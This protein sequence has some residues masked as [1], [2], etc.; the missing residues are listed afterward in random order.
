M[1]YRGQSADSL[2]PFCA[3]GMA[4]LPRGC[5]PYIVV[6]GLTRFAAKHASRFGARELTS[7]V[8]AIAAMS[9]ARQNGGTEAAEA[10]GAALATLA[11]R[12]VKIDRQFAPAGIAT[13][14][15][16]FAA[17]RNSGSNLVPAESIKTLYASLIAGVQPQV[18]EPGR[19]AAAG[20]RWRYAFSC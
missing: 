10:A 7:S 8:W 11:E 14:L 9:D 18:W 17:S 5:Q 20:P 1:S 19:T 3:S 16:A 15:W 2:V 13:V 4:L 6:S 12:A